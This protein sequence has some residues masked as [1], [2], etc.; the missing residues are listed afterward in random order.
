MFNIF[1]FIK[2]KLLKIIKKKKLMNNHSL[3]NLIFLKNLEFFFFFSVEINL[4]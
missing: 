4:L 1:I 2:I 3:Y